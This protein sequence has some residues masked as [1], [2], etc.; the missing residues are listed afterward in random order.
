MTLDEIKEILSYDP[1][2]GIFTLLNA[3]SNPRKNKAGVNKPNSG[4][5]VMVRYGQKR[6]YA[7]RLA[8]LFMT[9]EIPN[10]FI[11]H[12][13]GN[14]SN[15]AWSNLRVA[16]KAQNT[17]N[18]KTYSTNKSGVKGVCWN[19]SLR[20]WQAAIKYQYKNI[21]LGLYEKIEDAAEVVRLK[22]IELHG[23]FANHGKK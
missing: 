12:I 5:Y 2:T 3:S 11:D 7:H 13:D 21:Y 22:R 16:T 14:P 18:R 10:A 8:F 15:N 9:G 6:T 20:K 1:N 23:E 19:G 4:G 17:Y